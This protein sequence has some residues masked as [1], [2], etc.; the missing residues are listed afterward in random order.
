MSMVNPE[1][2]LRV[3][4][5]ELAIP[6]LFHLHQ[7][8]NMLHKTG[9]RA[10][11]EGRLTTQQWV[12]LGALSREQAA[13][14]MSGGDLAHCLMVSRQNSSAGWNATDMSP[15]PSMAEASAIDEDSLPNCPA[16][17]NSSRRAETP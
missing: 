16:T 2:D 8:A 17:C 1:N 5:A 4:G 13:S 11:E 12:V 14:G 15:S 7:C 6:T 3:T 10:V 9:T